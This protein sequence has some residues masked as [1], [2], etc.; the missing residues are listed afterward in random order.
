MPGRRLRSASQIGGSATSASSRESNRQRPRAGFA[1]NRPLVQELL[2]ETPQYKA[3][4]E[5]GQ[6]EA[7]ALKTLGADAAL[8]KSLREEKARLS[9]GFMAF[10]TRRRAATPVYEPT[11][12][13]LQSALSAAHAGRRD[14]GW[15]IVCAEKCSVGRLEVRSLSCN[16]R[17]VQASHWSR[18]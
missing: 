2:R 5:A 11:T 1:P 8:M 18:L 17:S 16:W 13:A 14:A 10:T 6:T 4:R 15:A 12:D 9:A 3:A 7:Q